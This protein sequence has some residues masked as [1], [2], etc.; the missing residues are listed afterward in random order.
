MKNYEFITFEG[1][2]GEIDVKMVEKKKE[3]TLE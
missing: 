3:P 2:D 1:V